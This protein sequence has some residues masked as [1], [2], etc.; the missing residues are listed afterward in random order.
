MTSSKVT[1]W[2]KKVQQIIHTNCIKKNVSKRAANAI[3]KALYTEYANS[4]DILSYKNAC[5]SLFSEIHDDN[6][7]VVVM[8]HYLVSTRNLTECNKKF[9]PQHIILEDMAVQW[10][11]QMEQNNN[12]AILIIITGYCGKIVQSDKDFHCKTILQVIPQDMK[13][14]WGLYDPNDNNTCMFQYLS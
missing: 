2:L 13:T 12:K 7:N 3:S 9:G 5:E 8:S 11:Q 6:I 1:P 4:G 10:Q 14:H